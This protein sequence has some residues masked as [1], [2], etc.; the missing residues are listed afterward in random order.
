MGG[1]KTKQVGQA[2]LASPQ[3]G[4]WINDILGNLN[5]QGQDAYSSFLQPYDPEQF[6][7]LFQQAFIDPAMQ[8]Y[9]QQVIPGIQERFGQANAGSSSALNQALASSASDLSTS[10]GS[11]MGQFYQQHQQNQLG[12]LGQMG[13][14]AGQR[15]L[16]PIIQKGYDP[17][18]DMIG[19]GGDIGGSLIQI[20]P[21]LMKMLKGGF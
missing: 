18:G 19:A 20:I 8:T 1:S 3:Q 16:D 10:L 13:G 21:G 2:D 5:Q 9:E 12:A 7:G 14:M 11:Q 6:Q 17:T 15:I 4:N